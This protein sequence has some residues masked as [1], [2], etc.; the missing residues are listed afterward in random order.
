M[1]PVPVTLLAG[2]L[3]SGK[4][5]L[6]N[7]ILTER[8]GEAIAV[9]VNEY[10]DVGIDGRL[11]VGTAE[12]VV[13]L[14]N[15]CLCCTVRG[16]L[17]DAIERMLRAR[18]RR[19]FERLLIEASG[20]ASP[21]PIV[22]TLV[23]D[24]RI[25]D[26]VALDGVVTVAHAV[27]VAD[28]LERHPE[29]AE[30]VGYADLVL[31]NHCDA[32]DAATLDRAERAL[33]ARN[34]AVPIERT[35]R[36]ACDV[37]RILALATGATGAWRL[38]DLASLPPAKHTEG[39][40]TIVLRAADPLDL[41]RLKMWIQ[42]LAARR[43]HELYRVK[44]ILACRDHPRAVVVQG[45]YQWLEL[46]PGDEEIPAES[47]LLLIGRGLDREEILRGWEACKPR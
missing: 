41:H 25:A 40:G 35:E 39:V 27:H 23:V 9:I 37:G 36:A 4:T 8:H 29:V 47:I 17:V 14:E 33:Q 22:Q 10:G 18:R 3:G 30:Q 11:V 16:D 43:T 44:G 31:L 19:P 24:G 12:E 21:G 13:Q 28:Q 46:G 6:V 1:E 45:T 2:F 32:A 15:G 38:A 42:F 34:A 20:L 26:A 5:T 7:R